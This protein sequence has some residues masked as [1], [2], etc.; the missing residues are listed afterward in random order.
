MGKVKIVLQRVW[1]WDSLLPKLRSSGPFP[2][3]IG[4]IYIS[5]IGGSDEY[6]S[7]TTAVP[8]AFDWMTIVTDRPINPT[9]GNNGIRKINLPVSG[10]HL[11]V[12]NRTS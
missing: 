4:V 9:S 6:L 3:E 12:V 5:S 7:Q 8:I 1:Q 2:C 11:V 10:V